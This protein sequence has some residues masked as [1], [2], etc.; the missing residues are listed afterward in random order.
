MYYDVFYDGIVWFVFIFTGVIAVLP[1]TSSMGE[2]DP[3]F[4]SK[5]NPIPR[6][7]LIFVW[8][9]NSPIQRGQNSPL[10]RG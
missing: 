7:N 9:Q 1:F 8:G 5:N 4:K 2:N 6:N 10:Q 3:I